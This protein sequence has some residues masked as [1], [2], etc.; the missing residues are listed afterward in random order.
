MF[1]CLFNLSNLL[2]LKPRLL[3]WVGGGWESWTSYKKGQGDKENQSTMQIYQM[4][5][6]THGVTSVWHRFSAHHGTSKIPAH[7]EGGLC[8]TTLLTLRSLKQR[9]GDSTTESRQLPQPNRTQSPLPQ[10]RCQE[11]RL[12]TTAGTWDR[13][14]HCASS[15]RLAASGRG[16][17]R[18]VPPPLLCTSPR[19]SVV[20]DAHPSASHLQPGARRWDRITG[21]AGGLATARS[22]G[23]AGVGAAQRPAAAAAW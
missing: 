23:H 14:Q 17:W 13:L 12:G 11:R 16:L 9:S 19:E 21:W 15:A 22:G 5:N 2:T 3:F 8:V 6:K 1:G 18:E 4:W 7:E 20:S 10:S